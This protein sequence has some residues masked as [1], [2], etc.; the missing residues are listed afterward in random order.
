MIDEPGRVPCHV[1]IEVVLS[2]QIEDRG[3]ACLAAP[4][5]LPFI[6]SFADVLEN[7]GSRG[8]ISGRETAGPVNNR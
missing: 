8:N 2:V 6:D 5:R 1:A 4:Q 3:V 7:A